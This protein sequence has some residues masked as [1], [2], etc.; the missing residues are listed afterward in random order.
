MAMPAHAAGNKTGAMYK[1]PGCECGEDYASYLR[2]QGYT[3]KLFPVLDLNAVRKR[4]GVPE[5]LSSCHL[6]VT[7]R[8]A[9]DG[10]VPAKYIDRLLGERPNIRGLSL[11]GKPPGSPGVAGEKQGPFTIYEIGADP[12]KTFA[13][14]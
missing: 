9:I 6:F 13:I 10:H 7:G 4:N 12:P 2:L 14:D 11:P 3:L 5:E 1:T 8:Y